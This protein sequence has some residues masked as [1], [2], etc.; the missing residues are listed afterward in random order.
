[1]CKVQGCTD[2][3]K[4]VLLHDSHCTLL[5]CCAAIINNFISQSDAV[6]TNCFSCIGVVPGYSSV[7]TSYCI[8]SRWL[9]YI[10]QFITI[11]IAVHVFVYD[12]A[13]TRNCYICLICLSVTGL[14]FWITVVITG[15]TCTLYCGIV[16]L[17]LRKM[18]LCT[19]IWVKSK[20]SCFSLYLYIYISQ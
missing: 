15:L 18:H 14:K 4:A 9:K 16:R 20:K 6:S 7:C 13:F 2:S 17:Y 3:M 10:I 1:M 11:T 5:A 12:V 19:C 8:F